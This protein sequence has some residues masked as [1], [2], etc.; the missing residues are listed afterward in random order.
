MQVIGVLILVL[1]TGLP[2]PLRYLTWRVINL[3]GC[4]IFYI[5]TL[6][7]HSLKTTMCCKTNSVH[8]LVV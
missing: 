7:A 4:P 6:E 5:V 3:T 2:L 1:P 8:S